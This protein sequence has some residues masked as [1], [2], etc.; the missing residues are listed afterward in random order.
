M[1]RAIRRPARVD[2]LAHLA[3]IPRADV[4]RVDHQRTRQACLRIAEA[5]RRGHARCA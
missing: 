1:L 3:E 5:M 4:R 2:D